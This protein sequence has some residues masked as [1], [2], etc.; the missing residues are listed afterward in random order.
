M[1]AGDTIVAD[2]DGVIVI[3]QRMLSRVVPES[4]ELE[5]LDA[6]VLEEVARGEVLPGLYPPDERNLTRYRARR[7]LR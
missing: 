6:W 4:I 7:G 1:L 3:P 5:R 2:D